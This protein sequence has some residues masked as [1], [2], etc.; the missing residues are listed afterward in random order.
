MTV[1]IIQHA[2]DEADWYDADGTP[3]A[4]LGAES[5]PLTLIT[6]ARAKLELRVPPGDNDPDQD[7][8]IR[9]LIGSAVSFVQD[10]LNIPILQERVYTVLRQGRSDAPLTFTSPGDPYVMFASKVRYL[11]RE[12]A[13]IYTRG[14]WP[15]DI[16]IGEEDQIAPGMGDGDLIAGTIVVK[17]PE[18]R[19]PEAANNEYA[20]FY[21]RG[22]KDTKSD[23]NI[24]R[25]LVILKMRDLFFGSPVMKGQESNTAY[26]RL[27]KIIRF[28]GVTHKLYRID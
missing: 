15:D 6:L 19:W 23:L 8:L 22:I 26:E 20:L 7:N 13:E 1:N 3:T 18:G 5:L 2:T 16:D 10:D 21:T 25:Q 11:A 9:G 27:A 12:G 14:D 17:P 28:L 24:I 4:E